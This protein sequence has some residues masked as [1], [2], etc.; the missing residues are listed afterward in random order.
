[1][2]SIHGNSTVKLTL[3]GE[4]WGDFFLLRSQDSHAYSHYFYST[5]HCYL[6]HSNWEG[7]WNKKMER[8]MLMS[9]LHL[10]CFL[11][12]IDTIL[13]PLFVVYAMTWNQGLTL[14]RQELYHLSHSSSN[15]LILEHSVKQE[16]TVGKTTKKIHKTMMIRHFITDSTRLCFMSKGS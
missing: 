8:H 14:A 1:M 16:F 10:T 2:K 11:F 12:C 3:I 4:K 15:R 13:V 7:E 5:Q 6:S 9:D